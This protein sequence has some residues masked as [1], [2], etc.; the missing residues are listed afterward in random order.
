MH[1]AVLQDEDFSEDF[2][3]EA[4]NDLTLSDDEEKEARANKECLHGPT[5]E[6]AACSRRGN[7][8]WD[9]KEKEAMFA[10]TN[11]E[12]LHGPIESSRKG[13][14]AWVVFNG[15]ENGVFQTWYAC[16]FSISFPFFSYYHIMQGSDFGT[17]QRLP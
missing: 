1:L 8:A 17:N 10:C 12:S 9:D 6:S 11:E 4:F 16:S 13:N 3:L 15:R 14:K 7:K 2:D 5:I